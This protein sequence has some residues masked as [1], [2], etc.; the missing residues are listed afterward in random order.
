MDLRTHN[1]QLKETVE[2]L[3]KENGTLRKEN[4]QLKLSM[5]EHMAHFTIL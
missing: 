5:E 1:S 4:S 2:K 3:K